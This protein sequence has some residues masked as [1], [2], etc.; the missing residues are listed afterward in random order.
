MANTYLI[1]GATSMIGIALCKH[2]SSFDDNFVYAVCR[3]NS[4]GL[5]RLSSKKN[6]NIVFYEI[7]NIEIISEQI[8]NVDIFINLAWTNTDH[9]G[10]NDAY[11]QGLNVDYAK[12]AIKVAA[13]M[14]CK[15]FVQAGSQAEYGVVNDKIFEE[16]QCNPETEYG[17]AKLKVL[18]EGSV[19]CH[20]LGLKYLHLRIFSVFGENDRPW[21][22]I[23]TAIE[24]L[25]NNEDLHLSACTQ[26]WNYLYVP[27]CARQIVLLCKYL[28][29]EP[30]ITSAV[31]H[32]ASKVTRPLKDFLEEMKCILN[33]SGKLLYRSV[34]PEKTISINPSIEKTSKA[35]GSINEISFAEAIKRI[36]FVNYGI[37]L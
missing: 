7:Q 1:T 10:R 21:T 3:E 4:E 23:M 27:D 17:K 5:K 16:A 9:Q 28:L 36:V 37:K 20:S 19:L 15:L 29:N 8:K 31:Y 25:L 12:N 32:I 2:I 11:L 30:Y 22:L 13:K 14:G 24:K 6:I 33:S 34:N 18:N 35:I 26:K